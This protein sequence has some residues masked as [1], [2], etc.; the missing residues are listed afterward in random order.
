MPGTTLTIA[1]TE[2]EAPVAGCT[3]CKP[4]PPATVDDQIAELRRREDDLSRRLEA[5]GAR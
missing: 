4:P 3:C 5:L 1:T 2:V